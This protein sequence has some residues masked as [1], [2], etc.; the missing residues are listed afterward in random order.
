[1]TD[2]MSA[3]GH[4]PRWA[5]RF[6]SPAAYKCIY[7][8]RA[9]AK[10]WTVARLLIA[11]AYERRTR[12]LCL[13]AV[14][15]SIKD[16]AKRALEGAI[17]QYELQDFF[18]IGQQTIEGSNGSYIFFSGTENVRPAEMKG[19]E[20]VDVMWY[21]EAEGLSHKTAIFLMPTFRKSNCERW[22]TWNPENR[23][24]WTWWRFV[25]HPEPDDVI[26]KVCWY[27]NPW[28]SEESNRERLRSLR[29]TPE[30]YT[31]TWEG[32]PRDEGFDTKL[33]PYGLLQECVEGYREGRHD[34]VQINYP[35]G[36]L[37]VADTGVNAYTMRNGPVIEYVRSWRAVT[38]DVTCRRA[39]LLSEHFNVNWMHVD[40]GGV[41]AGVEP[42]LAFV[43]PTR[44]YSVRPELF[45]G[46]VL[47]PKKR[48]TRKH[49]NAEFFARRNAQLGWA[50]RL[51][52][53][54][55][56]RLRRGEKHVNPQ[57]CLFINPKIRRLEAYLG[58][59][60]QPV[61]RRNPTT[62]KVELVKRDEDN[63]SPDMYDATV[64]AFAGDSLRGLKAR[65]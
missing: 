43:N 6:T 24:D 13:R 10:T 63:P 31:W 26:Q 51:R 20:D 40:A 14:Q 12:I 7:G 54:R 46:K 5:H 29:E 33:L 58:E 21:E 56:R 32:Q 15:K 3:K 30:L 27:D 35:E 4:L 36:G 39:D 18:R 17:H 55:T 34:G 61:W 57:D 11:R 41:G 8:G 22:F 9:S 23:T 19:W 49:T 48:Y 50:L 25:M 65:G 52:A 42:L 1:M 45:G 47:G 60:S 37:D 64:L 59:M 16:S 2:P 53:L 62:G 38:L 28:F 44:S